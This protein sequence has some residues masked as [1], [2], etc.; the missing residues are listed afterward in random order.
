MNIVADDAAAAKA[1]LI[2]GGDFNA[3]PDSDE[4]RMLVGRREPPRPGFVLFDAWDHT[5][6]GSRGVTWSN[7]NP[8]AAPN[9]LP[10]QRIDYV[11]TGWPRR[12]GAGS[13]LAA[14]IAGREPRA[15]VVA[16]DHYAVIADIRY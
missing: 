12:G 3:A 10:D 5:D 9:L 8:W 4:I 14:S 1:V 6:D 2:V 16:S 13:A 11:F 7:A 15:G